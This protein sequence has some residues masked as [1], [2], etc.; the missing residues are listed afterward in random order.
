MPHR[1]LSIDIL[2]GLVMVLMT[3]DHTRDFFSESHFEPTDLDKT[4]VALFLTRWITHFCAP[5]FVF[6][7]GT[8]A[9]LSS[10][11]PNEKSPLS[12]FLLKRGVLLIFIQISIEALAWNF[13]VDFRHIEGGVLWAIGWSMI[14]MAGLVRL[15]MNWIIGSG[16]LVIAGHNLFDGVQAADLGGFAPWWAILHTGD[17]VHLGGEWLIQ[18]YYPLLPWIGV[19][20]AGFAFGKLMNCSGSEQRRRRILLIL[21]GTLITSFILLRFINV[22]GD[23]HPWQVHSDPAFTALS[24]LNCRKYPPS[25]L[26]VLMTLGP[27]M[28]CLAFFDQRDSRSPVFLIVFGRTPLF[29]YI[30]HL[31]LIHLL[32][33]IL[34]ALTDGPVSAIMIGPWSPQMPDSYGYGLAVV[35]SIWLFVVLLLFPLCRWYD[36]FKR[37][38]RHWTWL[39]YI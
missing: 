33:V 26:Y 5:I 24:F 34:A 8:G 6:L 23:P 7:A 15:P 1:L 22:Y 4:S 2:R 11:Q 36:A 17:V 25:L 32:A 16:F 31:F 29:F 12:G 19:M 9:Y 30:V 13:K 38:N 3:L 39:K 21:G 18:P 14:V 28:V 37:R 27:A 10:V 20:A 35:Y